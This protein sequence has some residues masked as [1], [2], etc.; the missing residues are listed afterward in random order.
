MM[1]M[2]DF[3]EII[4]WDNV[5]KQK[6][7]YQNKKPFRF[8][9]IENFFKKE[10]YEKLY[11]TYPKIDDSWSPSEHMAKSIFMKTW[12]TKDLSVAVPEGDD[13]SFSEAWNKFKRYVESEEFITNF[14]KMTNV[15]VNKLKEFKLMAYKKGGFHVPHIH[16]EGPSTLIFTIYFSKG[17]EKGDPG[18]TYAC[19]D[20]DDPENTIIF[21]P[22]N[23]DNSAILFHD[24]PKAAHGVRYIKK[25]VV[26]QGLQIYLEEY[27]DE[28]GWSAGDHEKHLEEQVKIDIE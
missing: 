16:N 23:L 18:G 2:E 13:P 10:F 4:N 15:P 24:G 14:R 21:E 9:F 19:T 8:T 6:E 3:S 1:K 7:D 28:T 5:L 22:S 12:G 26:R 20:V 27:S 11:E 17:W 25:D